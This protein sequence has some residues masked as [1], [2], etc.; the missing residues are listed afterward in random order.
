M[1]T[2]QILQFCGGEEDS[3]SNWEPQAVQIGSLL[4][5]ISRFSEDTRVQWLY[6]F[7]GPAILDLDLRRY[8]KPS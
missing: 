6:I 3:T 8:T 5:Y 7:S 1:L 4:V 2:S